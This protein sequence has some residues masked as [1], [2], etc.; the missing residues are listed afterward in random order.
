MNQP[1]LITVIA[2]LLFVIASSTQAAPT[3][4]P[5]ANDLL[6]QIQAL[7]PPAVDQSRMHDQAYIQ[8][9]MHDMQEWE[10]KR[11]E[12]IKEFFTSFPDH[13]QAMKLMSERWIRMAQRGLQQQVLDETT[14]LLA[15]TTA[16]EKRAD[17]LF[18]RAAVYLLKS[19][20][21]AATPAVEEF[22]AAAPKDPRGSELLFQLARV[23]G[24]SEKQIAIYHRIIDQYPNSQYANMAQGMARQ[25]DAVGK[26]FDLTFNDAITGKK[27]SVLKD[28]KGKVVVIDFWA[29][30]C[31]P[32]VGEM[33]HNKEIYSQY[34]DK[35]VEF[36]G[37]S[38]DQPAPEG[39][40]ALKK[41]VTE[42]AIPWPQYYQGNGW[43]STFSSGWG[44]HS[45][46]TVFIIDK[47]GNLF[48]VTARGQLETLI[49]QLLAE[50][51]D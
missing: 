41:F 28:L 29:T 31:G 16:P 15:S 2:L 36:I 12:L 19:Q 34:K 22:I 23:E 27:I 10:Q 42:N 48:S 17:L 46:P 39:I 33:P 9:Y 25:A 3:T 14:P 21:A 40:D 51:M 7:T 4:A 1:R 50:Q 6:K 5:T 44:I 37:V 45:I 32:C 8:S 47:K 26:P 38:L 13:P 30:W 35:G 18:T 11:G 20:S 43:Q 49:P 24:N